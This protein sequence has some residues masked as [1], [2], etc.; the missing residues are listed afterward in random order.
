MSKIHANMTTISQRSSTEYGLR[1][2]STSRAATLAPHTLVTTKI[3]A[4]V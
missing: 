2:A 3:I 4:G 1:H